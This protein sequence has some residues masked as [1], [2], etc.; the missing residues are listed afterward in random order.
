MSNDQIQIPHSVIVTTASVLSIHYTNREIDTLFPELGF[1]GESPKDAGNK[2]NKILVWLK[3]LNKEK[4]EEAF[5]ILGKALEDLMESEPMYLFDESNMSQRLE[6]RK[7]IRTVLGNN[8]MEYVKGGKVSR[9]GQPSLLTKNLNQILLTRDLSSLKKEFDRSVDLCEK[10]PEAAI[11]A[12]CAIL[13]SF[14]RVYIEENGLE[15]PADKTL[16]TLWA[17]VKKQLGMDPKLYDGDDNLR[18]IIQGLG[19]VVQAIAKIRTER[20]SA[21]GRGKA[22]YRVSARH[23]RLVVGAAHILTTYLLESWERKKVTEPPF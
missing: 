1:P 6:A 10:D 21:H 3:R 5:D 22:I 4:P 23:A 7:R 12:A 2:A 13:E 18:C 8:G 11:T 9:I 19:S 16:I 15:M 20:G 17:L 14:C